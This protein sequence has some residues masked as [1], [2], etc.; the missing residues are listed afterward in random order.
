MSSE[1]PAFTQHFSTLAGNYDVLLCDVW[2]VVHNGVTATAESCDAL[3]Q[4]RDRGGVVIL[5][6]NAPRPGEFVI[7]F[8]DRMKVPRAVFDGIVSSGD[9]TRALVAERAGQR[10]FHLGPERDIGLFDGLHVHAAP[11][12]SADFVVCSGLFDDTRETPQDYADLIETMRRRGLTMIC[13]NPDVVV[14]RGMHLVYCAG[15]I[16]DLYVAAGGEVVFAGKPYRPIYE[17]ALAAAQKVRQGA[18][19]HRRVLAI[20]DSVRTDLKGAAAFGID[21]LFVTAGIHA[22]ELGGRENPNAT[23]LGDIF[24]AAGLYPTAVTRKLAW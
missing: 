9:V 19:E 15:A 24:A 16:A 5:I 21:C 3:H 13:A 2:G 1:L 22:E 6:T 10:V 17:Q 18:V 20:G 12:D 11:V 7:G 23:A 4:F 8:L 14:E